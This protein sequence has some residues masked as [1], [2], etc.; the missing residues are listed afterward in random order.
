MAFS[1][2]DAPYT[3]WSDFTQV[4]TPPVVTPDWIQEWVQAQTALETPL[5]PMVQPTVSPSVVVP[6]AGTAQQE[7]GVLPTLTN[8]LSKVGLPIVTG[9]LNVQQQQAK[10]E[11]MK[12][13]AQLMTR[14]GALPTAQTAGIL[15]GIP[16]WLLIGG[17]AVAAVMMMGGKKM[18]GGREKVD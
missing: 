9:L 18:I 13:Q 3:I 10:A 4:T 12:A 16:S 7:G 15:A 8:L 1:Q 17:L 14:T 6:P 11:A 5:T 2:D